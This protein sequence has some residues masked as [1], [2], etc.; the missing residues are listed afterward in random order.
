[1]PKSGRL[2]QHKAQRDAASPLKENRTLKQENRSL[3]RQLAK[4]RKQ[5]GKMVES[6][7]SIQEEAAAEE[8]VS[9]AP[10]GAPGQPGGCVGCG[11]VGNIVS[12]QIP[13]SQTVLSICKTCG[14]KERTKQ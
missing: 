2:T 8:V 13:G 10:E 12:L 5:M 4:L 1:M 9:M 3:K 11:G 7:M 14:H 6:H